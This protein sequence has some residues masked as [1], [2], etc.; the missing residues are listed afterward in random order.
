MI[1]EIF[2]YDPILGE[3][4][5]LSRDGKSRTINSWNARY[6][7]TVAGSV[8]SNGYI[9]V[10]LQAKMYKA[11]RVVWVWMTGEWPAKQ[12]DHI[13]LNRS[14][15]RWANLREATHSENQRN[16]LAFKSNALGVRGVHCAHGRFI[17]QIDINGK[18]IYLGSRATLKEAA[19]LYQAAI[20]EHHGKFGRVG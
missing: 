14:D 12:I 5:W 15:N 18:H 9:E 16:A 10:H 17:A 19:K 3:L 1:R 6:T 7:D 4:R 20:A 13:N 2:S 11:H 8:K